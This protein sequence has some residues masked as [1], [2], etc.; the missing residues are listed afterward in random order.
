M[1]PGVWGEIWI[2][3]DFTD[4][5]LFSVFGQKEQS[6]GAYSRRMAKT[7]SLGA[8]SEGVASW[9]SGRRGEDDGESI[10]YLIARFRIVKLHF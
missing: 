7:H 3:W 2:F 5:R 8:S 6:E 1:P 4:V 9:Q 10:F